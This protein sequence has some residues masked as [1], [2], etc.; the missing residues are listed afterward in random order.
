MTDPF[1]PV[2]DGARATAVTLMQ[3][4][5]AALATLTGQGAPF[6]TRIAL[7][8]DP[9]GV[10][11]TLVSRLAL[12]TEALLTG[13]SCSLLLGE[14]GDKGDPLTHPRLTVQARPAPV[15]RDDPGFDD[16]AQHYI[17]QRPKAQLYIGFTDFLLVRLMPETA[18][19]NG[20]FG[21]AYRLTPG[22]LG[23]A[24]P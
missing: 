9:G 13:A 17:S 24:S 4:P 2:G 15:L 8:R 14:P 6:V 21:K 12:H 7:A 10:P 23:L 16:L 19:L 3:L 5:H 1:R 11:L 18:F 22:D 20:G